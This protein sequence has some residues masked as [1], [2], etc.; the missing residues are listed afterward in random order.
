LVSLCSD[1]F[2]CSG[3]ASQASNGSPSYWRKNNLHAS[4]NFGSIGSSSLRLPKACH[5]TWCS[6]GYGHWSLPVIGFSPSIPTL[7]RR[8]TVNQWEASQGIDEYLALAGRPDRHC[9]YCNTVL[10]DFAASW[11]SGSC[12]IGFDCPWRRAYPLM[13]ACLQAL[14]TRSMNRTAPRAIDAGSMPVPEGTPG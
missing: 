14:A 3:P 7:R 4:I 5:W 8:I 12:S 2:G 1:Q 6:R 10:E 11:Y 13:G 9:Y